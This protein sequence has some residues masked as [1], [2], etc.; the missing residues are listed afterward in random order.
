MTIPTRAITRQMAECGAAE[1][2]PARIRG[3]FGGIAPTYDRL[4]RLFSGT[5]DQRW[6]RVTAAEALRGLPPRPRVLD[7]ATGTGDLAGALRA[8]GAGAVV[9]ADFTR[10]MLSLAAQKFGGGE[11]RWIEADGTRLPFAT[12]AFDALTVAFGLR[13]MVDRPA[14]L[15][16]MARVVRPGGCVAV[17]EFGQPRNPLFS[18]VYDWY[19]FTIM[20][21]LG[22]FISGSDA[23]LYLAESIRKFYSADELAEQMRQAGLEGI[24]IRPFMGGVVYLHIGVVAR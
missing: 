22:Q 15:R 1:Q 2:H 19:S 24:S 8:A 9:G 20:P 7:L 3:M 23:Y 13:N 12:D 6:R 14:A 4:N 10:P 5:L 18:R 11:Y 21:R 17:L 16:E